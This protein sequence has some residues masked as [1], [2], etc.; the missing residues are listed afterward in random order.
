MSIRLRFSHL[1]YLPQQ[2][3]IY[4]FG[5]LVVLL[6]FQSPRLLAS[7]THN[8]GALMLIQHKPDQYSVAAQSWLA[9]SY[10]LSATPHTLRLIGT[11][12]QQEGKFTLAIQT[13]QQAGMTE[14][15][16]ETFLTLLPTAPSNQN[17]WEREFISLIT[18]STDWARLGGIF[19]QREDSGKAVFAYQ[20]ALRSSFDAQK[21]SKADIY[22][23]LGYIYQFQLNNFTKAL[24]AYYMAKQVGGFQ[25]EWLEFN[26]YLQIASLELGKNDKAALVSAQ[27][28]TR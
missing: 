9:Y 7:M 13:W 21:I 10:H 19:Q 12:Y 17:D 27:V 26:T 22:Y 28:A 15:A 24:N 16:I 23:N 3:L 1:L 4:S 8:L 25:D 6:A 18:D 11:L 5:L 20:Q 2:W 14:Y